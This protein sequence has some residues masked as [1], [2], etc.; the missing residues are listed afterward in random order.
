MTNDNGAGTRRETVQVI[1]PEF[2]PETVTEP[3]Q[4]GP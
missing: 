2:G 3:A 4:V 1:R